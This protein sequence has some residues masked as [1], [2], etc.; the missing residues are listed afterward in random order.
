[1]ET[2]GYTTYT[3][4]EVASILKVT[5][6]TVITLLREGTIAGFK[7]GAVWRITKPSLENFMSREKK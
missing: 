4:H 5:E 1:M 6:K 2:N 7:V 3:V